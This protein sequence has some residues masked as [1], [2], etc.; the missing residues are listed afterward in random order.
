MTNSVT[1]IVIKNIKIEARH[2]GLRLGELELACGVQPGYLS[3]VIKGKRMLTVDIVSS[4][5]GILNIDLYQARTGWIRV[6]PER[7]KSYTYQCPICKEKCYCLGQGC[8]YKFCPNCGEE[9]HQNKEG[10]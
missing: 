8:S 3:K 2:R 4:F 7:S 1:E 6:H 9:I 5:A 10:D